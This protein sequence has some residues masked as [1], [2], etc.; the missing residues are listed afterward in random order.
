MNPNFIEDQ[1]LMMQ[2]IALAGM[3]SGAEIEGKSSSIKIKS[4]ETTLNNLL[5]QLKG[6][7]WTDEH[8]HKIEMN[9]RYQEAVKMME[10]INE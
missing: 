8:G 5:Y 1:L 10:A 2:K 4:L 3:K 7:G 6:S 9:I